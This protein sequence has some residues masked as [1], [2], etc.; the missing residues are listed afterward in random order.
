MQIN[1]ST[2]HGHV[3]EQTRAKVTEK[4]EKLVRFYDRLGTIEV[5]IDLEH[6]ETPIVDLKVSVK[7]KDFVATS[8]A[9]E[10]MASIDQVID[11]MEHQ[12]R[13]HKE[14]VQGRHHNTAGRQQVPP[15]RPEPK[16]Q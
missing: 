6:R 1:I 9:E 4:L 15:V 16:N 5:I 3:S 2:R 14:K 10:L 12:L 7:H 13:K 8:R 11:K